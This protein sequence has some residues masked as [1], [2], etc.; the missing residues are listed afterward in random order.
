M[1]GYNGSHCENGK[2]SFMFTDV[3]RFRIF[4]E[5]ISQLRITSFTK[6]NLLLT[7]VLCNEM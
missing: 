5:E 4:S 2:K 7:T 6:D 3:Y 1:H